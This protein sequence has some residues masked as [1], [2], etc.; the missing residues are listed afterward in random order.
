MDE[1]RKKTSVSR[2]TLKPIEDI[3][4]IK[5]PMRMPKF[6]RRDFGPPPAVPQ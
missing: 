2:L 5:N 1:L 4:L 3:D 6:V